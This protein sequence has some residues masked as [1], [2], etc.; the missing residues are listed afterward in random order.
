MSRRLAWQ[1]CQTSN[2]A[3]GGLT[4]VLNVEGVQASI[5]SMARETMLPELLPLGFNS[6]Q[7]ARERFEESIWCGNRLD[8]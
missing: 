8:Q 5:A 7:S 3:F 6:F 2:S 4:D 1:P